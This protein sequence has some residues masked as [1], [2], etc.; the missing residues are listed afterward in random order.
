MPRF[1]A[2]FLP[3]L[4]LVPALAARPAATQELQRIAVIVNDDIISAR[5]VER[6]VDLVVSSTGL[7]PTPESRRRVREQVVRLLIDERLQIQE[8]SRRNIAVTDADFDRALAILERQNNV[9]P[10]HFDDFLRDRGVDKDT[11]MAQMRAE[12]AWGKLI[13]NRIIP[14]VTISEDEVNEA[15]ATTRAAAGQDQYLV[16]E[17]VLPVDS[18]DQEDEIRRTAQRLFEQLGTGISFAAVARQVSRGATAANGG[19]AGWLQPATL[20]PEVAEALQALKPGQIAP[21]VR[22]AGAFYI[23]HLRDRRR[24]M[25]ADPS[26]DKLTLKQV[27]V[28][29]SRNA[30]AEAEQQ[31]QLAR[32]VAETLRGCDDV[33]R[34]AAELGSKESGSLGTV[35]LGDLPALFRRA[36][37][38]LK[39]GQ[40]AQPV[41]GPNA[42]HVLAVCERENAKVPGLEPDKVRESLVMRRAMLMAQ[43]YLRDLRRDATVELR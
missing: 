24:I 6:R 18:V 22:A 12:I 19:D 27:V 41:E 11:L 17:I 20:P 33:D 9:R 35:R 36:V 8:A 13:R 10:G 14:T 5:D 32:T 21:P 4:L 2:L 39:A 40:I 7:P 1:A 29:L 26:D 16:S 43:R 34:M 25:A 28:P 23:V 15:I 42:V 37:Q 3:I 38:D 30:P 31:R